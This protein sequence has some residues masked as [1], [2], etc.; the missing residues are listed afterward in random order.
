MR[1]RAVWT[2]PTMRAL[3]LAALAAAASGGAA[4]EFLPDS[5]ALQLETVLDDY[6]AA[7]RLVEA[8]VDRLGQPYEMQRACPVLASQ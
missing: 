2:A 4:D 6:P 7:N 5:W 8:F 1:S 3:I